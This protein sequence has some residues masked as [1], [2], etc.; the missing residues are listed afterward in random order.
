MVYKYIKKN[1]E[2]NITRISENSIYF[3][4]NKHNFRF[5]I[6][7]Y[8]DIKNN[9]FLH[10]SLCY[11]NIYLFLITKLHGKKIKMK[12]TNIFTSVC[13]HCFQTLFCFPLYIFLFP[14]LILFVNISLSG[15][16][17]I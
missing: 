14:I 15:S 3:S 6:I 5:S 17:H 7:F 11:I 4:L 9:K 13:A 12:N 1:H 8:P 2:F 16:I 10:F